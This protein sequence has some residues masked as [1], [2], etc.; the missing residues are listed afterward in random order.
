MWAGGTVEKIETFLDYV[1]FFVMG[2]L[3]LMIVWASVT[4]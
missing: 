3:F 2:V 4:S 1:A